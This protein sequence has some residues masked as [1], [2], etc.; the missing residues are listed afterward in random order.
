MKTKKIHLE[1]LRIIAIYLVILTHTGHRGFTH[2]LSMSP[3]VGYFL[4]MCVP[5]VCQICVPLFY[6]I[7]GAT[8]ID[9][10]ETPGQIWRHRIV[11]ILAV[12]FLASAMMY[13]YYGLRDDTAMSV[14][15]LLRSVYSRNMIIPYWYLYSYLGLLILLPF[16]RKMIRQLSDREMLYLLALHL[17][18]KGLIP[19]L[20]YRLSE[21]SLTLNSSLNLL[22]ATSDIV[23]FPAAGY[24][25]ER[26]E[27][28]RKQIALL[29][30]LTV[31][32]LAATAYMT[33]YKI[34]LT[35][36][37]GEGQVATFYKCL[38][39]IPTVTVYV[40]VRK[41]LSGRSLPA[42]L[43][44]PIVTVGSCTFGIYL[45]EQ[46]LRERGYPLRDALDRWLPTLGATMIYCALVLSAGFGIVWVVKKIPGM[47][48]LI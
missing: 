41:L 40:T 14:G 38:C 19:M 25:F 8:L 30:L 5:L 26:K 43:Q 42:W 7:T 20:Q 37:R 27:L 45:I 47:K 35:G 17:V 18:F 32:A 31:L 48:K 44:K 15:D 6:M 10:D 24:F 29:W 22:L 33:H 46:I 16:L 36:Q 34:Q 1:A 39:L 9:R 28:S 13:V 2:Y 3:S 12:L 11:R 23:V 21:G 4:T